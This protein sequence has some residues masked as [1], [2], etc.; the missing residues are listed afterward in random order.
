MVFNR[1]HFKKDSE[2]RSLVENYEDELNSVN[3]QIRE[4]TKLIRFYESK[5]K[6][7]EEWKKSILLNIKE[8]DGDEICCNCKF[9]RSG[10]CVKYGGVVDVESSCVDFMWGD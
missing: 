6:N 10:S 2:K 9:F 5:R 4:T 8:E 7:L 1:L 3:E